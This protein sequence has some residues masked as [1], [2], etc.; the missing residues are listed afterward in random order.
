MAESSSPPPPP[1]PWGGSSNDQ[2][3]YSP[4]ISQGAPP[5]PPPHPSVSYGVAPQQGVPYGYPGAAPYPPGYGFAQP[6]NDGLAIAAL[7]C[8]L[9]GIFTCGITGILAVIFGFISRSRIKKSNGSLI[10]GGM[11]LAGII[12][13]FVFVALWLFYIVGLVALRGNS[14]GT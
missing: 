8:S 4:Q 7:V 1:T 5:P 14:V 13:G 2:P 3:S 6:K 10:G 11:A 12:I 9:T